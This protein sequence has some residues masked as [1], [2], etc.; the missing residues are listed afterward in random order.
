MVGMRGVLAQACMFTAHK[1]FML[2]RCLSGN[3]VSITCYYCIILPL[4][5][6]EGKRFSSAPFLVVK[7]A[8][9]DNKGVRRGFV[10]KPVL[11]IY[12]A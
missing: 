1:S 4:P 6:S 3:F 11:S 5:S 7:T 2:Q 10:H 8:S 9:D 12:P